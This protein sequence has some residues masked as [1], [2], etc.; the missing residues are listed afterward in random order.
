MKKLINS[1]SHC[2][3]ARLS[4]ESDDDIEEYVPE[5]SARQF[6]STVNNHMT[7]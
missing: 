1:L 3:L 2:L 7:D 5:V 6:S 4:C